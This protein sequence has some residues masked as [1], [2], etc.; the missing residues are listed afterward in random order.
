MTSLPR[1]SEPPSLR[2]PYLVPSSDHIA[3][4]GRAG[5]IGDRS[6]DSLDRTLL[7]FGMDSCRL[8][9]DSNGVKLVVHFRAISKESKSMF[10]REVVQYVG[11]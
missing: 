1:T 8:V 4:S 10:Q 11:V 2:T 9:C 7:F 6:F 3:V 5:V